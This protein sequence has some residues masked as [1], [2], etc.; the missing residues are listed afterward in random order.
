MYSPRISSTLQH[1]RAR[2]LFDARP[3]GV[4][5]PAIPNTRSRIRPLFSSHVCRSYCLSSLVFVQRVAAARMGL[6]R[7]YCACVVP[8]IGVLFT[9]YE[10]T[11]TPARV[12]GCADQYL[13][14]ERVIFGLRKPPPARKRRRSPTIIAVRFCCAHGLVSFIQPSPH[15]P[16]TRPDSGTCR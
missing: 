14:A 2:Q 6:V 13:S 5:N 9:R 3:L 12:N 7:S 1:A 15:L 16:T 10:N 11:A 8:S 4:E